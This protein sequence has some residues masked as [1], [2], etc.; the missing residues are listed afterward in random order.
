VTTDV[1]A[2]CP[3][4][5]LLQYS[6]IHAM[7]IWLRSSSGPYEPQHV[8]CS[9]V[10]EEETERWICADCGAAVTPGCSHGEEP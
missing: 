1:V 10:I 5:Q 8:P 3:H 2:S 7:T 4:E 9:K 6:T